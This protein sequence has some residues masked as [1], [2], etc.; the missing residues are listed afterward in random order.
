MINR[1][2]R[3]EID[4]AALKQGLGIREQV[5]GRSIND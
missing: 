3:A 1:D 5:L 4:L 2:A